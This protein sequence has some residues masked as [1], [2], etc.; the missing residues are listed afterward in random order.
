MDDTSVDIEV[1]I[2]GTT[3]TADIS[4][5][6]SVLDVTDVV[7]GIVTDCVNAEVESTILVDI[8][9]DTT[10]SEVSIVVEGVLTGVVVGSEDTGVVFVL[11]LNI[12]LDE[13]SKVDISVLEI[14][15]DIRVASIVDK[16]DN[17]EE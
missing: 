10:E 6:I 12:I 15:I 1:N 5:V 7:T 13:L 2:V 4:L 8:N 16:T 17:V 11:V 14:G 3:V 9:V